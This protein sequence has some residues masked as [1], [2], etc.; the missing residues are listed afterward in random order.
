MTLTEDA[1]TTFADLGLDRDDALL[2]AK[3]MGQTIIEESQS[4]DTPLESMVYEVWGLYDD[5]MPAC[6]FSVPAE[7][8]EIV[9]TGQFRTGGDTPFV[10]RRRTLSPDGLK[11]L[12]EEATPN[13]DL[14]A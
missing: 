2:A 11:A 6:E 14:S 9:F 1:K 3:S 12:V 7:E 5:G 13:P 4:S 10:E 8:D